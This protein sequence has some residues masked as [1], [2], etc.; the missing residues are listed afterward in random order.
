[1]RPRPA[2][3]DDCPLCD[4]LT[5]TQTEILGSLCAARLLCRDF[6]FFYG[7]QVEGELTGCF[8]VVKGSLQRI[9]HKKG[10]VVLQKTTAAL[11]DPENGRKEY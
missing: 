8:H 10:V 7:C 1:M 9:C 2:T 6:F 4:Y 5:A 3:E 11:F